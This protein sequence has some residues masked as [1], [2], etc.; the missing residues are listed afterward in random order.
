MVLFH[1]NL[2]NINTLSGEIIVGF[3]A[4]FT[5]LQGV[6]NAFVY[7]FGSQFK[8]FIKEKI[9]EKD[10]KKDVINEIQ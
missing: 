9:R 6:L 5:P 3:M 2:E 7:G 10:L 4:F 8:S 1:A